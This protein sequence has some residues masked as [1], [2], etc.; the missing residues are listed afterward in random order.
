SGT[1][2]VVVVRTRVS[3]LFAL[4]SRE[5]WR[6]TA[7]AATEA[8]LIRLVQPRQHVLQDRR[9]CG[10]I[11][12][13]RATQVLAFCFLLETAARAPLGWSPPRA[14]LRER[15]GVERAPAMQHVRKHAPLFRRRRAL[16]AVGFAHTCGVHRT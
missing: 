4:K 5:S 12:R 2:P 14:A 9:V 6:S 11:V 8:G 10:G 7:L 13:E 1:V 15:P 3:A 16:E